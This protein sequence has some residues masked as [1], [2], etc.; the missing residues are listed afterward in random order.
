MFQRYSNSAF[1]PS[2]Q[3]CLVSQIQIFQEWAKAEPFSVSAVL[4][5]LCSESQSADVCDATSRGFLER[6]ICGAGHAQQ[7]LVK[8]KKRKRTKQKKNELQT[9]T[10]TLKNKLF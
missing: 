8:N 9:K 6:F 5:L 3:R 4:G 10:I 1:P 2:S 7:K